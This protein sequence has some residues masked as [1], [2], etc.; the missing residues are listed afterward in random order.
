MYFIILQSKR[1]FDLFFVSSF[2]AEQ[3]SDC[4]LDLESW[5]VGQMLGGN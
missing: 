1:I 4:G 5:E 2:D 3:A